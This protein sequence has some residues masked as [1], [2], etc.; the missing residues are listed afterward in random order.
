VK[1]VTV[2]G[3]GVHAA[4]VVAEFSLEG[5]V[6]HAGV[7][8]VGFDRLVWWTHDVDVVAVSDELPSLAKKGRDKAEGWVE[9]EGKVL[10]AERVALTAVP[11]RL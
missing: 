4:L 3:W 2:D 9:A 1:G 6:V 5:R 10:S 11:E 8:P 7:F